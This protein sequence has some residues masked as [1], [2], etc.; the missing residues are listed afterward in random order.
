MVLNKGNFLVATCGFIYILDPSLKQINRTSI[1]S[2]S[3]CY[4]YTNILAYFSEEEGGYVILILS[5]SKKQI[6]YII[7]PEGQLLHTNIVPC[8][9]HYYIIPYNHMNDS[10]NYYLMYPD[11]E[12]LCFIKYTY[13]LGN[14]SISKQFDYNYNLT[15]KIKSIVCNLMKNN[16]SNVITCFIK[17]SNDNYINC[18][19]FD[20]EN[21]FE[22]IQTTKI[23]IIVDSV[24]FNLKSAV[25]PVDGRQKAIVCGGEYKFLCAG[26]D[27]RTNV[28]TEIININ[29][30][31]YYPRFKISFFV[32]NEKFIF[33]FYVKT[34][35]TYSIY[36]INSNFE[37]SY[38]GSLSNSFLGDSCD[39]C[40]YLLF[41]EQFYYYSSYYIFF[42]AITQ[43][44]C[45]IQYFNKESFY[46][47]EI[48]IFYFNK[49]NEINN[50]QELNTS[51]SSQK[52]L[53]EKFSNY[54]TSCTNDEYD[55]TYYIDKCTTE[56]ELSLNHYD[57]DINFFNVKKYDDNSSDI[58][59]II[60]DYNIETTMIV[61]TDNKL[62]DQNTINTDI[63]E[64]KTEITDYETVNTDIINS[65]LSTKRAIIKVLKKI[66]SQANVTTLPEKIKYI[67]YNNT[68]KDELKE[69]LNEGEDIIIEF[70]DL[71]YHLT[72]S[73][74]QKNSKN[75]NVSTINL[76]QCETILKNA[77]NIT[78]I[79]LIIFIIEHKI[80]GSKIP[81]I[82]Y[83]VYHPVKNESLDLSLC[84]GTNIILNIPVL[85]DQDKLYKYDI[86]SDYYN[87]RCFNYSADNK[88]DMPLKYRRQD[89]INNNLTLCHSDCNYLGYNIETKNSKCECKVKNEIELF[90]FKID[91]DLL[92]NK[93]VKLKGS[94][95]DIIK[96]YY[97]IFKPGYLKNNIGNYIL[98]IIII[99][100][101]IDLFIFLYKGNSSLK[102]NIDEI[103][104]SLKKNKTNKK[105]INND[106]LI[107]S[108]SIKNKK[109]KNNKISFP[110]KNNNNKEKIINTRKICAN[111]NFDHNSSSNQAIQ[112]EKSGLIGKI[113]KKNKKLQKIL[114]KN[115]EKLE[116][117][118]KTNNLDESNCAIKLIEE[119]LNKL[120]YNEALKI[121]KRIYFQY[122]WSLLKIGQLF[123]FSF[124]PNNDYNIMVIKTSLFFFSF[125]LYYTVN[126][127]FFTDSTMNKIY[128][129]EYPFI[130]QLP[131]IIY[132]N[133]ISTVINLIIRYLTLTSKDILEIRLID[134]EKLDI[135][136][137]EIKKCIKIKF[138]FFF[139]LSF[140]F[141]FI[142]WFYVTIFCAVYQKTQ[143]LLIKD[144]T[145]SFGLSLIYPFGYYLLPGI[146]R[147]PSLRSKTKNREC[148]YRISLLL[149]YF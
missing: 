62:S 131:N 129:R 78:N 99:S 141:L 120:D 97:L 146:F 44:Y 123:L 111:S 52:F 51:Y 100:S 142:F 7:S 30:I 27:I 96:Y 103:A 137:G 54:K 15:D 88:T 73:D 104:S 31:Y 42:S 84:D 33:S 76:G 89:F 113:D 23:N 147:I 14:N 128:E 95:I 18:T 46:I 59:T 20:S 71:I 80:E 53:C 127:L 32:E 92:Y 69:I 58:G 49:E 25:M 47:N 145:I 140:L 148:M 5:G 115:D 110:P 114:K 3:D 13:Y 81:D 94:N 57:C 107:T 116:C 37:Y 60:L 8:C 16:S 4:S 149:Q 61:Q 83:K 63:S 55:L 135:K 77:Y 38:F 48:T 17:K 138:I 79:P 40:E 118:K 85:I 75:H 34:N 130:Y 65:E 67:F 124:F 101:I 132:S 36:S 122:Y 50:L 6:Q 11:N 108:S 144:T 139:I 29:Q 22:I 109:K 102:K 90:N 9:H 19:V 134:V 70:D 21:N 26:Y 125:G 126:S 10:Y 105:P 143:I 91:K 119:E 117:M 24:S 82:Q 56:Y 112:F 12:N 64:S 1:N 98:S 121:D 39:S 2:P 43:N 106:N 74:N 87:D 66:L 133:L 136:V 72:S 45:L 93:F 28:L 86:Y 68:I 41:N 35:N